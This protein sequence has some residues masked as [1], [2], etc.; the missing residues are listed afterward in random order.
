MVR[1]L[2]PILSAALTADSLG[3]NVIKNNN[4]ALLSPNLLR[5]SSEFSPNLLRS[6]SEVESVSKAT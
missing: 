3:S 1:S 6:I 5:K 4:R 2:T